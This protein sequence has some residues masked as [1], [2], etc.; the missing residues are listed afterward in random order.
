MFLWEMRRTCNSPP[1]QYPSLQRFIDMLTPIHC[2]VQVG[3]SCSGT[4]PG[5][6]TF[7][8]LISV[9]Q[10]LN[11]ICSPSPHVVEQVK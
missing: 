10:L 1:G 6:C 7:E 9:A 11:L 8:N 4:Q 2:G 3:A 5:N